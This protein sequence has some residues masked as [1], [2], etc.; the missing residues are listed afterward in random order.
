MNGHWDV[1]RI[2]ALDL[3]FYADE[4]ERAHKSR[5]TAT[6]VGWIFLYG[7]NVP[8]INVVMGCM[9]Y[10]D[11]KKIRANPST[12]SLPLIYHTTNNA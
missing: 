4:W 2:A 11:H 6:K 9:A 5:L 3:Y 8:K 1:I 7:R 12:P 10:Y